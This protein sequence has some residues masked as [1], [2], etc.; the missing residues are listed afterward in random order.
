MTVKLMECTGGNVTLPSAN[1]VLVDRADGG[2]LVVNP[3]REVW[4]RS[5][6]DADELARWS[7]LVAA[8]GRAM[9][10]VLPQLSLGCVNYWE[11]GNWALNELADP[12]GPKNGPAHRRVHLHLLGRSREAAHPDLRWGQAPRFPDFVD[13]HDWAAGFRRLTP[14]ECTAVVR[15]AE[16]LLVTRWG[17]PASE[18]ASSSPCGRCRY[19]SVVATASRDG[20]CEE[21]AATGPQ[22]L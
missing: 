19:P 17:V 15:K 12:R 1:L 6:L 4:E 9:I 21:C 22:A 8:A 5:E 10:D 2:N 7:F 18:V 13:R 16:D 14:D 20:L 11:A 3:P